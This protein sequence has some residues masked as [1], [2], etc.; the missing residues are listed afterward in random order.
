MTDAPGNTANCV[1]DLS[2]IIVNYNTRALLQDCLH[3][4]MN[5]E[6]RNCEVIVVDNASVDGSA[7]MAASNFPGVVLVRNRE[8]AGF[9]RANN[10]GMKLAR[11]KY[12]LLLNFLCD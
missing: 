11:G 12:L 9:A 10:Q 1:H 5:T 8:N 4:L 3:S 2:I 6:G 7:E